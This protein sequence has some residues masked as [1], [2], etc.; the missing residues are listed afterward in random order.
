MSKILTYLAVQDGKIKRASLEVL[1]HCRALAQE[2]GW[3]VESVLLHPD[4]RSLAT[5]AQQYGAETVY[6]MDHPQLQ[7]HLNAPF[8]AALHAVI[9][10]A[11]PHVVA[12]ASSEAV[13]DMLGALA[14][15]TQA[16]VLSDVASFHI[17]A[18]GVEAKRPVMASKLIAR[19][20]AQGARV[21]VSV[22]AGA[23][24]AEEAPTEAAL[25]PLPFTF[26]VDTLKQQV[27]EVVQDALGTLDLS[28]TQV[29]VAAGRGVKDEAGKALVT[30]L[31]DTLGAAIG[32]SRAVVESGLFP[33]SA[34]V[35]QTGK[36][37]SPD[38]YIAVGISGAIQHVAGMQNSRVIVAINKDGDA[39]IFNYATYGLVGDLYAVL[40][41]LINEIKQVLPTTPE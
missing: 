6:Y 7:A 39:P 10:H 1:S 24:T 20:Q 41:P 11:N 32:A 4:A 38:L 35:G 34:Q 27:R 8:L 37:V 25:V 26:D 36:V 29:V 19:T 23:Y 18:G 13:K 14:V 2:H 40:P 17:I 9:T 31:A 3:T 33:A 30:Q 16:A 5:T 22:R 15:R 28:E 12:F 21:L